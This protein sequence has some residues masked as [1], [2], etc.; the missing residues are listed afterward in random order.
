VGSSVDDTGFSTVGDRHKFHSM[1]AHKL[2]ALLSRITW[3]ARL[4][5]AEAAQLKKACKRKVK[6][7]QKQIECKKTKSDESRSQ[8]DKME[9]RGTCA[10]YLDPWAC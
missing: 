1:I 4:R 5:D 6:Q 9:V 8:S 3:Q 7:A 10:A 2:G